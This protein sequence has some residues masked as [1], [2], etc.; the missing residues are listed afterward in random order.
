MRERGVEIENRK[1]ER[2]SGISIMWRKPFRNPID[3]LYVVLFSYWF[4]KCVLWLVC[5]FI[6]YTSVII[7]LSSINSSIMQ[8][9]QVFLHHGQRY[10]HQPLL[11]TCYITLCPPLPSPALHAL[12]YS[13]GSSTVH[14][15]HHYERSSVMTV[16][17]NS[18][19]IL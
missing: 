16:R 19:G 9:V 14:L 7:R 10:S 2:E 3:V 6:A 13:T 4:I 8:I 17:V 5:Q 18:S 12:P 15:Y 11:F 1:K